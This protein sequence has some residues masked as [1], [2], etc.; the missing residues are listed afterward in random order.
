MTP[1]ERT[2][3]RATQAAPVRKRWPPGFVPIAVVGIGFSIGTANPLLAATA[4]AVLLVGAWL[5]WRPDEAPVLLIVFGIAWLGAA[6]AVLQSNWLGMP[7]VFYTRMPSNVPLA[8]LLSLGGVLAMAIGMRLG[9]GSPRHSQ[10][11][12]RARSLAVAVP[13]NV[14]FR[15]YVIALV[16][17]LAVKVVTTVAPGLGQL[18]IGISQLRW[19]FFF[20][21][22]YRTFMDPPVAKGYFIAAFLIELGQGLGGFFSDFKFVF[23]ASIAAVAGTAPRL[24]LRNSIALGAMAVLLVIFGAVWSAVKGDY[25][26][27]LAGGRAEQVVTVD[28]ETRMRELFT[29][30]MSLSGED[31]AEGFDSMFRRISYVE[32]F[33]IVLNVVPR[34]KPHTE[35]EILLDALVRPAMPRIL[36][37]DKAVIND[38]DRTNEFTGGWAGDQ[39]GTSISIGYLGEFYI[40][41]GIAGMLATTLALGALYGFIYRWLVARTSVSP[42]IG[43]GIALAILLPYASL[44]NSFTK[45]FGGLVA[46]L[47]AV[48]LTIR[49]AVPLM[50][51]WMASENK[52]RIR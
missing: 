27:F 13:V 50:W 25:R 47:I 36:F 16:I 30:S 44:D 9:A 23:L 11:G 20:A 40:D 15:V 42:L 12:Q 52:N 19:A 29:R 7:L 28:Y 24:S 38:T 8:T 22:A 33:G 4:I 51:P 49:F 34:T 45:T 46:G 17:A 21:L 18:V 39:P 32:F 35:G 3:T 31:L 41:F 2:G 26:A 10:A 48:W 1:F 43:T 37:P 14:W 6:T 5:L